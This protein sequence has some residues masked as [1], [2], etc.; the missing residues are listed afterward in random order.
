MSD[1]LR[2]EDLLPLIAKLPREQQV[3]LARLALSAARAGD[4]AAYA[5]SP[6][7]P[8]ELGTEDDSLGW[9]AEGWDEFLTPG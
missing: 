4:A 7:S 6:V 8:A 1:P 3:K 5:A 9:D 2:A